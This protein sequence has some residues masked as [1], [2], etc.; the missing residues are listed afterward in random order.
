[1]RDVEKKRERFP[2]IPHAAPSRMLLPKP[3]HCLVEEYC[4]HY[5]SRKAQL[6][7]SENFPAVQGRL[8][9]VQRLFTWNPSPLQSSKFAVEYLLLPPRSTPGTASPRPMPWAAWRH[10]RPPT[11]TQSGWASAVRFSAL[12]FRGQSIRQV[13]CYTLL[14]GFQLP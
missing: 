1:M 13:S 3:I 4:P 12:H 14:S 6:C 11:R 8:T 5:L 2:G 10:L 7:S 9:H